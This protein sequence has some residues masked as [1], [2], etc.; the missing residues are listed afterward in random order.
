MKILKTGGERHEVNSGGGSS[1]G[2]AS[3]SRPLSREVDAL[4]TNE[5]SAMSLKERENILHEIH[6]VDD[7]VQENAEMVQTKLR[8]LKQRLDQY[9]QQQQLQGSGDT[10]AEAHAPLYY[11]LQQS[12]NYVKDVNFLKMFLRSVKWDVDRAMNKLQLFFVEKQRLFGQESLGRDITLEQD[13]TEDDMRALSTGYSQLL[14]GRDNAGRAI[15]LSISNKR[16]EIA[17]LKCIVSF[18][19]DSLQL[20]ST[21][22]ISAS[23]TPSLP[24]DLLYFTGKGVVLRIDVSNRRCRNTNQRCV[25]CQI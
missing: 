24:N 9:Q 22:V 6:G 7:I 17:N 15:W 16:E 25:H 21:P 2:P 20:P 19:Q 8:E 18:S 3:S 10:S 1:S 23:L 11:V 14:P 5:L 12:P 4:L 13:F